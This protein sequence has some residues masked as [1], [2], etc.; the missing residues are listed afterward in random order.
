MPAA[1]HGWHTRSGTLEQPDLAV[2]ADVGPAASGVQGCRLHRRPL[3]TQTL[4]LH[5]STAGLVPALLGHSL[6]VHMVC[7]GSAAMRQLSA[8]L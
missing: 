6:T 8:R 4:T 7:L 3:A 2:K 1:R 5:S